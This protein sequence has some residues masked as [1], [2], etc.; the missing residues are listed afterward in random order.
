M[1][2]G[3][4]R[5]TEFSPDRISDLSSYIRENQG[6]LFSE[7]DAEFIHRIRTPTATAKAAKLLR[8][9]A[10]EHPYA[11]EQFV[12]PWH[13]AVGQLK[14]VDDHDEESFFPDDGRAMI[15]LCKALFPYI[16]A[17]WSWN[18]VEFSFLLDNNLINRGFLEKMDSHG[19][20][21]ISP[22]GW[23]HLET[24]EKPSNE[25]TSAFVAMWF[26]AET[27]NLWHVLP[28]TRD[29]G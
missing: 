9:I 5:Q 26:N 11:G 4:F 24:L 2:S 15:D 10:K 20:L 21:R 16:A 3:P 19:R 17:S 6:Q 18:G 1:L 28:G 23:S 14:M 25:S 29:T 8:F 22:E 7:L 12:I 27:H 13:A